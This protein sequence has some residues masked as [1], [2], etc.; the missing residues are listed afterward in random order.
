ME[1]IQSKPEHHSI[2]ND[3]AQLIDKLFH[4]LSLFTDTHHKHLAGQYLED[5]FLRLQ[6]A[7][8]TGKLAEDKAVPN[9]LDADNKVD[10]A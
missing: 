10:V 5:G 4:I 7:V 9:N 3:A 1:Q 2:I 8:V 6:Q